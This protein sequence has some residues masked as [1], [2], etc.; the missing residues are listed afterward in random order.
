MALEPKFSV[1]IGLAGAATVYGFYNQMCPNLADLRV[2]QADDEDARKAEM[3]ARWSSAGFVAAL[4]L[5]TRDATVFVIGG[6]MVILMSWTHRYANMHNPAV[7]SSTLP[8]SRT[9]MHAG[10]G[11]PAG[12]TPTP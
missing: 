1:G 4:G 9:T 12:Y 11:M 8:S 10:D 2:G 5:L 7:G 3:A 6:A